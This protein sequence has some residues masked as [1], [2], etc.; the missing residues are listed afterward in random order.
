MIGLQSQEG[1]PIDIRQPAAGG[2]QKHAEM[3]DQLTTQLK[4]SRQNKSLFLLN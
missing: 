1:F 4:A 2:F 3:P